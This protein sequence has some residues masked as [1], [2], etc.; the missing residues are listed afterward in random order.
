MAAH[1]WRVT[2]YDPA[3]RDGAGRFTTDTW[4]SVWD[5]GQDFSG[6]KLTVEEY[7]RT[8]SSY[9]DAATSF[10]VESGI[11]HLRVVD[12]D[13]NTFD[14]AE[15]TELG[16]PP[17][18][19]VPRM[20]DGSTISMNAWGGLI[21]AVL[22]ELTWCKLESDPF[23]LHFGFDYYMYV[24]SDSTCESSQRTTREAGLFVEEFA[25]PYR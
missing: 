7:V 13:R 5:I 23:F 14:Q 4:T 16:V 22:R 1:E 12:L 20:A 9:V 3:L 10:A 15:L 8:E 17:I 25:S 21:R 6:E 2:K 11:F 18:D 19:T 24:G